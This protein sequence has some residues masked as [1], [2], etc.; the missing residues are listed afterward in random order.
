MKSSTMRF[1]FFLI[2]G[3][4]VIFAVHGFYNYNYFS[5]QNFN[6][7][8]NISSNESLNEALN[9]EINDS[10]EYHPL[11]RALPQL[12]TTEL[13]IKEICFEVELPTSV[14]EKAT[15]LMFRESLDE[16]KGMLYIFDQP[17]EI[18][19][20]AKNC[21]FPIDAIWIS[22]D[23]RIVHIET[24]PPCNEENCPVYRNPELAQYVLEINGGL[25]S[26]Y[27]FNIGDEVRFN[28]SN[29]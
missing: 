15:G 10:V 2:V 21:L 14:E 5:R 24:M 13:C 7:S 18:G 29:T 20:W 27:D 12:Q 28:I 3:I 17:M 26:K 1:V 8:I 19:I 16:D 6:D 25:A 23:K 22:S 9:E 11:D 4:F